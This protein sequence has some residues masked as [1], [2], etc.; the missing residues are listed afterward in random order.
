MI[1]GFIF[2]CKTQYD[3]QAMLYNFSKKNFRNYRI[4]SAFYAILKFT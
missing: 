3:F 2:Y 4:R 1:A